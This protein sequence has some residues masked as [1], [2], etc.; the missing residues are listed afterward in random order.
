LALS[1]F[2]LPSLYSARRD[3]PLA[4]VTRFHL[5]RTLHPLNRELGEQDGCRT[6]STVYFIIT[7]ALMASLFFDH[8]AAGKHKVGLRQIFRLRGGLEQLR[9][10]PTLDFTIVRYIHI[11]LPCVVSNL[12]CSTRLELYWYVTTKGQPRFFASPTS[13]QPSFA[14]PFPRPHCAVQNLSI[15]ANRA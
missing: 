9:R 4:K 5:Q 10:A 11:F 13:W 12:Q 6:D 3:Q 2:C 14:R 8:V 7:L 1:G 15:K